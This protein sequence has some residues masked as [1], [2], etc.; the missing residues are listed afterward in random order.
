M[1]DR[2]K[3]ERRWDAIVIGARCAGA[4]TA[5]LL[6]RAG[7]RVLVVDRGAYGSDT[8]STHA[9][10]RT[11]V[12][13]LHRWGILGAIRAAG[14]PAVRT[15]T[16]VYGGEEVAVEIK[17]GDGVDALCAPRRTVLDRALADA[18]M[19]A[20]AEVRYATSL[21]GLVRDDAGRV[22]GAILRSSVGQ[23]HEEHSALVIG[24]D[25]RQSTL[26]GLVGSRLLSA[27]ENSSAGI[28]GYFPGI[29]DRG[30]RWYFRPG[31]H[32]AVI[33]TN[34]GAHCVC[35]FVPRARYR[36]VV[37]T[38]AEAG[39]RRLVA[40]FDPGIGEAVAGNAEIELRRYV[41]APGHMR[42]A[43]GPGWA[44]VGDAGYFKDP[45]T[46]HGIT[47]ALRD[48]E[49]LAEAVIRSG[50]DKLGPYQE[51][52]DH[53][54]RHLFALTDEIAGFGWTFESLKELHAQLSAAMKHEHAHM[55]RT[56]TPRLVA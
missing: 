39:H 8:L 45:I 2:S 44:L 47:D 9:L 18:A 21:E 56:E 4:A 10:M 42:Q 17:P 12:A 37:G 11:G 50:P 29:P 48:A 24:A 23:L 40:S 14:T 13:L 41:G 25:G 5:M 51:A 20:G 16:F 15:T 36:D 54:S 35:A 55:M 6:A 34:D 46:A 3:Q 22:S 43:H 7:A 32:M 30:Y 52:R 31:A 49:L 27:T 1:P 19:A 26:A 33:P 38:D 53:L 28:F